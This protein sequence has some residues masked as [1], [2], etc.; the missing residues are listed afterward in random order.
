MCVRFR[1][2]HNDKYHYFSL[3]YM[4]DKMFKLLQSP[5][6]DNMVLEIGIVKKWHVNNVVYELLSYEKLTGRED[7]KRLLFD[8]KQFK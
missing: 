1:F 3:P 7:S 4:S 5:E 8:S 2:M 6:S